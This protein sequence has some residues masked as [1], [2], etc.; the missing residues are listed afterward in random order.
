MQRIF[1][2]GLML[3]RLQKSTVPGTNIH[4]QLSKALDS[5]RKVSASINE[6][7][8]RMDTEKKTNLFLSRLEADWVSRI[9]SENIGIQLTLMIIQRH[10]PR[11]SMDY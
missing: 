5:M 4:K 3:E 2:Y 9:T 10:S 1:K 6:T 8:T 7:K 11:V